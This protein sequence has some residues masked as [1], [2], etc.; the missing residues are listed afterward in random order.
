MQG[1]IKMAKPMA[2]AKRS[3]RTAVAVAAVTTVGA[4]AVASVTTTG[5][6]QVGYDP[7]LIADVADRGGMPLDVKGQPFPGDQTR[8]AQVAAQALTQ[9]HRG[10]PFTVY[11]D[12]ARAPDG[13]MR[14][15]IVANPASP[16]SSGNVCTAEVSGQAVERGG[17]LSVTAALCRGDKAVTH[18]S[19]RATGI[20]DAGDSNVARLFRQIGLHLYPRRNEMME[21][22]DPIVIR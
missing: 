11:A 16:V 8:F 12:P 22:E 13:P 6:R 21:D 14:T 20:T 10:P 19:G 17:T 2:W 15:V 1:T 9:T 5:V 4:C 3:V 7:S 18:M